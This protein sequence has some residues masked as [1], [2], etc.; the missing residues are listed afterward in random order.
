MEKILE[1]Q[2][3]LANLIIDYDKIVKKNVITEVNYNRELSNLVQEV[4]I[5]EG[6][7]SIFEAILNNKDEEITKLQESLDEMKKNL[8]EKVRSYVNKVENFKRIYENNTKFTPEEIAELEADYENVVRTYHPAISLS[9]DDRVNQ[10]FGILRNLYIENDC[11][12]YY[13]L[14]PQIPFTE[15]D[16]NCDL[17]NAYERISKI[18][19]DYETEMTRILKFSDNF[20][21]L[22][23]LLEDEMELA[24][25]ESALRQRVYVDKAKMKDLS[26]QISSEFGGKLDFSF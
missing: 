26:A 18:Y 2:K 1:V 25:E 3:D 13:E 20:A 8:F 15:F 21:K 24:R 17:E 14:K 5:L 19:S 7:I 4:M 10:G 16:Q 23:S 22:E 12:R 6:Q 11:L 9:D